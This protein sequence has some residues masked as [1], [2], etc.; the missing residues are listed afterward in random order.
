M[1]KLL[2]ID[3]NSLI[4]RSFHALPPLTSLK[5]EP[6]NAVYGLSSILLKIL[7]DHNPDYIVAAF[8]RPEPTFRDAI[9]T[10]YKAHRPPTDNLLVPQLHEAHNTFGK[11]GVKVVEQAGL[12]ADDIVGILAEKFKRSPE[13]VEGKIIIF[14]GDKDNLQLVD[15]DK[16]VVELL[17]TGVSKTVVY[18]ESLFLQH[19][20]FSPRQLVDYKALVGDTSDNIPGVRGIGPK[21]ATD[22]I[23][24][25]GTIEKIYEDIELVSKKVLKEK[26]VANKEMALMSRRLAEIKRD[27]PLEIS[28]EEIKFNGLNKEIIKKYFEELGFKSLVERV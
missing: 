1:K 4:H 10:Q 28:L 20:G 17:K 16:V 25:F 2:L 24:E 3:A 9:F 6:I 8:D 15:G 23:K 19:Y 5:G 12:E 18:N 14:S 11:F 7:R 27:A 13:L 21:G 26:L 22:L